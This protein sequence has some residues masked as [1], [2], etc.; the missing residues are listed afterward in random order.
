VL[1]REVPIEKPTQLL[2]TLKFPDEEVQLPSD[3]EDDAV[4][5]IV[6][7]LLQV[8]KAEKSEEANDEGRR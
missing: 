5:A 8:L 1:R 6:D 2:L 7:L 4:E 3:K